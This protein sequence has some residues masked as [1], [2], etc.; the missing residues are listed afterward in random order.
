MYKVWREN[1]FRN[2]QSILLT[3]GLEMH[4]WSVVC[5]G[6][7]SDLKNNWLKF[8][9]KASLLLSLNFGLSF[10]SYVPK[11]ESLDAQT[12]M[13]CLKKNHVS[14]GISMNLYF[15]QFILMYFGLFLTNI[16]DVVKG[17]Y[18]KPWKVYSVFSDFVV[19]CPL[20]MFI[21]F[22]C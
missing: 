18:E 2:L 10:C 4:E 5:Y 19:R 8:N 14:F 9:I 20:K 1:T 17:R 21:S 15:S 13:Q 16:K 6:C 12:I 7:W 22:S 11:T 3:S